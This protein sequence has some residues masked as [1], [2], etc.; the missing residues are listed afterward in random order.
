MSDQ[1]SNAQLRDRYVEEV[2]A[3][4]H[5]RLAEEPASQLDLYQ[6]EARLLRLSHEVEFLTDARRRDQMRPAREPDTKTP[7]AAWLAFTFSAMA[8]AVAITAIII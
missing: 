1:D 7:P 2:T 6:L 5:E 4:V 8:L 3:T